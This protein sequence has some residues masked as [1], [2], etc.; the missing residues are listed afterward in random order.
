MSIAYWGPEIKVGAPQPA[1]NINMDAQTNVESVSCSFNSQGA[2]SLPI[3]FIQNQQ[4]KVP[5]PI[6]IPTS[7][8]STRRSAW[9]RRCREDR[10]ARRHGEATRRS[11]AAMIGLAKRRST[12]DAVTGTGTLDVARYGAAAESARSW[13][14]VRGAGRPF[15]GLHYVKSVTHD[16]Q[17]RR[18][19]A[20]L[21]ARPQRPDLDRSRRCRHERRAPFFGKYRGTVIN[22]VDPMQIGRI[23]AMVPD[24][25]GPHADR[26]GRCPACR[27]PASDMGVFTVPQIGAG[28]WIE[29]EQG[30]PDYPIWV[31]GFWGSAAEVP[32]LAHAVPPGRARHHAAD[33][34]A[35]TASSISDLPGPTGGILIKTTTGAMI[36]VNDTGII[37]TNGKGAIIIMV[38]PTADINVGALTVI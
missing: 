29:F 2:K 24:V 17:A 27:S 6:P 10:A 36:S 22:N 32:A 20:E 4:T 34:A 26:A 16:D 18:V 5:I 13:S 31:G 8:R 1:L 33:D 9:C 30:D 21:H 38:G 11:R 3:V 15:D 25:A 23:Q 28:V 7:R 37:I 35:R 14:G 12:A 19:Q